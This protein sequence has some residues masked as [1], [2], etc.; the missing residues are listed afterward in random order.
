MYRRKRWKGGIRNGKGEN[1][2][3]MEKDNSHDGQGKGGSEGS[4]KNESRG[5]EVRGLCGRDSIQGVCVCVWCCVV[6]V[7]WRGVLRRVGW[8]GM[9][10]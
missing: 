3:K 10:W 6:C 9:V 2:K 4:N 8:A 5:K 7:V 1:K